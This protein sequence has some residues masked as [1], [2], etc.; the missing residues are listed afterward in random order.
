MPVVT[1]SIA[2]AMICFTPRDVEKCA[3]I[4]IGKHTPIGEYVLQQRLTES[5][6]YGGDVLQFKEDENEVYAIHRLWLLNPKER[7]A[8]RIKSPNPL[9]RIITNGCIN[10]EPEIY[11]E[12]VDC[13]STQRL[14]IK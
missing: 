3:P 2:L 10:V 1:V 12:L 11:K 7:R 5:N 14:I 6:G 9:Q 8:E 4:L 13:C